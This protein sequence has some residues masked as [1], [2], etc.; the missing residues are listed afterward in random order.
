MFDPKRI[1]VVAV[2]S[3]DGILT[4][5][6]FLNFIRDASCSLIFTQPFLVDKIDLTSWEPNRQVVFVD[7]AVDNSP[8]STKTADFVR[9]IEEE[10]H[11][12]IAVIDEHD[13]DAWKSLLGAEKFDHLLIWPKS[14]NGGFYTSSGK[15]FRDWVECMQ[16]EFCDPHAHDLCEAADQADRQI[17]EGI[18]E[19]VNRAVKPAI[20]DN[21]RRDYLARYFATNI[22]PDEKIKGWLAEYAQ[23]EVNHSAILAEKVD[24]GKGIWRVSSVGKLSDATTIF[25]LCYKAGAKVVALENIMFNKVKGAKTPMLSI[26]TPDKSLDILATLQ[27]AKVQASGFASKANLE[28][29]DE[30]RAMEVIRKLL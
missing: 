23:M 2:G 21:T 6:A 29:A 10:G 14:Q 22:N 9:R 24:L 11:Q 28:L 12:L 7:L 3:G 19:V 8:G 16:G 26:A 15:V 18:G 27:A 20:W 13:A 4:T 1:V 5:A 25:A 17:F 30:E